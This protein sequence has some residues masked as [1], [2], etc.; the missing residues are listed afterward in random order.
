MSTT[1]K[2]PM[3]EVMLVLTAQADDVADPV[4]AAADDPVVVLLAA[5]DPERGVEV[6]MAAGPVGAVRVGAGAEDCPSELIQYIS[7]IAG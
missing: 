2:A 3:I 4:A 7:M 1:A 6:M 5:A